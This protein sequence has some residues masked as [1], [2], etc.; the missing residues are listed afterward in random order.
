MGYTI[1]SGN[2]PSSVALH[3]NLAIV[4]IEM[5]KQ[6]PKFYSKSRNAKKSIG[7]VLKNPQLTISVKLI[8]ENFE[9]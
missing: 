8:T 2:R 5:F 4:F 1:V 7:M 9:Y 3:K 6:M